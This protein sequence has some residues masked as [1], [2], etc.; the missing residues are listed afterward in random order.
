MAGKLAYSQSLFPYLEDG[1]L[2]RCEHKQI[3]Q[4]LVSLV[5]SIG[6]AIAYNPVFS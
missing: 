6:A 4:T 3:S 2:C 1:N 5:L